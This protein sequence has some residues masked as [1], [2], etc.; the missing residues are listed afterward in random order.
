M[1]ISID[2]HNNEDLRKKIL[3]DFSYW[4]YNNT[5]HGLID[6]SDKRNYA[7]NLTIFEG[8]GTF[9][10]NVIVTNFSN[11]PSY[12]YTPRISEDNTLVLE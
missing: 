7:T 2:I 3:Q 9:G 1:K 10:L 6:W 8:I 5:V 12:V 4:T 11:S